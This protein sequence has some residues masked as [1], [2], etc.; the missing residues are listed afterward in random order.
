MLSDK[1][2]SLG[3]ASFQHRKAVHLSH[4]PARSMTMDYL[5]GW[6]P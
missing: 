6:W 1:I 3:N 5:F 2:D 4:Q